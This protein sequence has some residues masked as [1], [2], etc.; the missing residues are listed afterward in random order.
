MR[1]V[2]FA[3]DRD[4]YAICNECGRRWLL[5]TMGGY[6][7]D[8][9]T[10]REEVT[11]NAEADHFFVMD[12]TTELSLA[13][14][15][16]D[17]EA[18]RAILDAGAPIEQ[19]SH[20]W[21]LPATPS[22]LRPLVAEGTALMAA[23][24]FAREECIQLL[25]DRGADPNARSRDD[26]CQTPLN[27]AVRLGSTGGY[28]HWAPTLAI[29]LPPQLAVKPP[30]G[31][32]LRIVEMLLGKGADPHADDARA[33]YIATGRKHTGL[34]RLLQRAAPVPAAGHADAL[35]QALSHG[36]RETA[37]E[38]LA[39]GADVNFPDVIGQTALSSA[40]NDVYVMGDKGTPFRERTDHRKELAELV[41]A[42]GA[43]VNA[44]TREGLTPLMRAAWG[45]DAAAVLELLIAHGADVNAV[46][47]HGETALIKA[48]W[49]GCVENLEVLLEH[50]ADPEVRDTWGHTALDVAERFPRREAAAF[51]RSRR[52]EPR[53]RRG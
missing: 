41:L 12:P 17:R 25:L 28:T 34:I 31:A 20:I 2:A 16:G 9:D 53:R 35:R 7:Q 15:R 29:D 1:R 39:Q 26:Y 32:D 44:H 13:A 47:K 49:S 36:D 3:A 43:D 24:Y 11:G 52:R 4:A 50:G 21:E 23:A 48:A 27:I 51:L 37:R 45:K 10:I 42:H 30:E 19:R 5:R 18:V 38:L 6:P 40:V 22:R 14:Q 46:N 33:L 8:E